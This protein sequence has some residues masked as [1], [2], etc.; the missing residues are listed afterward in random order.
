MRDLLLVV[1]LV[2]GLLV[3]LLWPQLTSVK[4]D[5]RDPYEL[6]LDASGAGP[7]HEFDNS[8]MSNFFRVRHATSDGLAEG[9][10]LNAL[11]GSAA[12]ARTA[13]FSVF[14]QTPRTNGQQRGGSV[15]G[16]S[17]ASFASSHR[18]RPGRRAD[19]GTSMIHH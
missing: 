1:A 12:H 10:S 16:Q 2:A 9:S 19:S 4:A 11:A 3:E 5:T 17:P 13:A 7:V 6:I 14:G 15:D 18:D 8:P